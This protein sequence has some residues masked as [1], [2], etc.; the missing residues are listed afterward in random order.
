MYLEMSTQRQS[1]IETM[2]NGTGTNLLPVDKVVVVVVEFGLI[3]VEFKWVQTPETAFN[4]GGHC[5]KQY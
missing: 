3:Y 4:P 1:I 2:L 5:A